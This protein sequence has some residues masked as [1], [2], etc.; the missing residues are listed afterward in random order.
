M[1]RH[2]RTALIALTVLAAGMLASPSARA[3]SEGCIAVGTHGPLPAGPG[4]S[5]WSCSFTAT[6]PITFVAATTNPFVI[7]I[8][9]DGG[10]QTDL[11]RRPIMGPPTTGR[12]DTWPGDHV[13]VSISCF[14]YAEQKPCVDYGIGGRYGV[15]A[16]QSDI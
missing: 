14:N 3:D 9:R 10:P 2:L 5:P 1:C 11:V 12:I 6:G 4:Y 13:F 16:A 8:S 15:V 7:S